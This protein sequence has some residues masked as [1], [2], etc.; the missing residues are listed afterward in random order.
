[1]SRMLTVGEEE[2]KQAS[3][4]ERAGK[5]NEAIRAFDRLRKEYPGTWID[6]RAQERLAT[7]QH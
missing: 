2:F 1:M 6:R 4:L 5:T 3:A 7:L